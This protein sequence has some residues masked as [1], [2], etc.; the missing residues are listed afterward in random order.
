MVLLPFKA[1]KAFSLINL[2]S[3]LIHL[4]HIFISNGFVRKYI[5]YSPVAICPIITYGDSTG[6]PPIHVN[7][8]HVLTNVQ[9]ITC[10]IG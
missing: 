9:N 8:S 1:L 3:Y 4:S 5:K 7:T 10:L 6:R 2:K